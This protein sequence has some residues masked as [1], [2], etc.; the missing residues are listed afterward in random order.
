[1]RNWQLVRRKYQIMSNSKRNKDQVKEFFSQKMAWLDEK[2]RDPLITD[3]QFRLLYPLVAQY[4]A[5]DNYQCNPK[6]ETLGRSCAKSV[7]TVRRLTKELKDTEQITKKKQLGA[8]R[9]GFHGLTEDLSRLGGLRPLTCEQK[10]S[11]LRTEDLSPVGRTEPPFRTSFLE[12]PLSEVHGDVGIQE[13]G[14]ESATITTEGQFELFWSAYPH[15]VGKSAARRA[16][17]AAIKV[18]SLDVLLAGVK[19]YAADKPPERQWLNPENFLK[20]QRWD[21]APA[22][23]AGGG[24][25][26]RSDG[27]WDIPHGTDEYDAYRDQAIKL[28]TSTIYTFPDTPGHVAVCVDRWPTRK[29]KA[30]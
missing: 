20:Q 9:Y 30:G 3:A 14:I 17:A 1:M 2:C 13:E 21:D 23:N 26:R 24:V 12:P 4:L 22:K 6:D 7:S 18:V 29:G 27:K 16:F 5:N 19:K 11:Q 10:T 15:K 28:N 25:H 8:S